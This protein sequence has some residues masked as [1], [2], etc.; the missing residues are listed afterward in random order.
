[1]SVFFCYRRH[2]LGPS[3]KYLKRF[4]DAT[5]FDWFRNRWRAC[6]ADDE[7]GR[8]RWLAEVFGCPS[9]SGLRSL[10][11]AIAEHDLSVPQTPEA[12]ADILQNHLDYEGRLL[13]D[14]PHLMQ[15]LT[16]DDELELA[17]YFFDDE[18]LTRHR[19][20][21]ALLLHDDW[22]L[23]SGAGEGGFTCDEEVTTLSSNQPGDG[24]TY[25]AFVGYCESCNL[26]EPTPPRPF[27][28]DGTRLPD[29][30]RWFAT[31]PADECAVE[32]SLLMGNLFRGPDA[33]V[34]ESFLH[35]IRARPKD[36]A[37][38]NAYADWC[39]EQ[40]GRPLGL[41]LLEQALRRIG[42]YSSA[43]FRALREEPAYVLGMGLGEGPEE[44]VEMLRLLEGELP[45]PWA[46]PPTRSLWQVDEHC[47]V[48]DAHVGRCFW[49]E[50]DSFHQWYLFDDLWASAHPGLASAILRFV[51]RWDVLTP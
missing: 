39:Q 3:G 32:I 20:R 17:Y 9:V 50:R 1:M 27:R 35:D 44:P 30:A 38:W 51:Q 37:A 19:R 46:E 10:F 34:E 25:L 23:P 49:T 2:N 29:L 28:L 36:T 48:L 21:A 24:S 5:V 41:H 7:D 33:S 6:P 4:D 26:R 16:D 40:G 15:V 45:G 13:L 43:F 47:A 31:P 42:H 22:R 18:Y 14:L 11:D 12:L 8:D